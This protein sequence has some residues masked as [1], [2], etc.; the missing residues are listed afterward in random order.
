MTMR[1][2]ERTFTPAKDGEISSNSRCYLAYA[3]VSSGWTSYS[4]DMD[5]EGSGNMLA[6]G[7]F[8]LTP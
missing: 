2:S 6:N 3:V 5:D 1:V 4:I 7:Y 8:Y